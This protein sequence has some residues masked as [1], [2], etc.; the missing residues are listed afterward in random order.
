MADDPQ[1]PSQED[2]G[3][4]SMPAQRSSAPG[5][6]TISRGYEARERVAPQPLERRPPRSH[7]PLKIAG[8][9]GV[10]LLGGLIG[11][12]VAANTSSTPAHTPAPAPAVHTLSSFGATGSAVSP[13]FVV[14]SSPVTSTYGYRCPPGISGRFTADL[15]MLNGTDSH[16]IVNTTAP[17]VSGT[18]TLHPA[19][20]GSLYRVTVTAPGSC[21]YH[22]NTAV[23]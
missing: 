8:I 14:S 2:P 3:Q 5:T 10:L 20:V 9:I 15:A 19:H 21:A 23:P 7:L 22:V 11:G 6:A 16:T 17:S 4:R 1:R 12:L 13:N 18:M